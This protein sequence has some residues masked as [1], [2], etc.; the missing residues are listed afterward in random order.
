MCTQDLKHALTQPYVSTS[1]TF[2][3]VVGLWLPCEKV[4]SPFSLCIERRVYNCKLYNICYWTMFIYLWSILVNSVCQPSTKTLWNTIPGCKNAITF[5]N[6]TPCNFSLSS[7]LKNAVYKTNPRTLDELKHNICDE[8]NISRG[9]LQPV[10][11]NF[12]KRCQKCIDK[13]GGQCTRPQVRQQHTA[14]TP[15]YTCSDL[16]VDEDFDYSIL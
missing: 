7:T 12:I 14:V 10:I 9:E 11:G 6:M 2:M 13:E 1:R 3:V 15:F 4:N 8:I 5:S 16:S